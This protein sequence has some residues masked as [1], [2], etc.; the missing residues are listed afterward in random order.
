MSAT[1]VNLP[2][3]G[4][5]FWQTTVGKKVIMAVTGFVLFGFIVGHLLGNLRSTSPPKRSIT[6]RLR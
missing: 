3:G 2:G 5:R 4:L 6:T 1:A